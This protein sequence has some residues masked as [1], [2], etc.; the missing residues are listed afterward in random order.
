MAKTCQMQTVNI[1]KGKKT[2]AKE[3]SNILKIQ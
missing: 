3:K 2:R 1:D